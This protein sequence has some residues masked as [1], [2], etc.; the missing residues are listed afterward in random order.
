MCVRTNGAEMMARAE[1]RAARKSAASRAPMFSVVIVAAGFAALLLALAF[2]PCGFAQGARKNAAKDSHAASSVASAHAGAGVDPRELIRQ[3]ADAEMANEKKANSYTYVQRSETKKID[4]DGKV[5]STESETSEVMVL[6]GEHVER[7]IARNDQPLSD[8]DKAKAEEKIDRF[9]EERKNE[10]Q[11][12]RQ[13]RLANKQKD[14]EQEKSYVAE[15]ADAYNFTLDGIEKVNGRDAYK[16]SAEP[17]PGFEPKSRFAKFLPKFH[18]KVWIDKEDH[19]W[20]K[21]DAEALGDV[22]YGLF[23]VRIHKNSRFSLEQTRVNDEVWLPEHIHGR[24]DARILIFKSLNEDLDFTYRDY[25]K[26][27]AEVKLG[28]TE[29]VSTP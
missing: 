23:L 27:R 3:A 8:K 13:K 5:A 21:L 11:E 9:M 28:A 22:S 19:Q 18:F 29:P 12:Q 14:D 17:R 4:G 6:Y 25:K 1:T 7:L 24:I 15:I 2:S 26:Y 20:V 10:T 16:I